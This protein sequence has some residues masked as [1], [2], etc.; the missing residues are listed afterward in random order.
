[1]NAERHEQDK[2]EPGGP[3]PPACGRTGTGVDS[4][5][6]HL[7]RQQ[8]INDKPAPPQETPVRPPPERSPKE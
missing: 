7:D 4:I 3:P 5:L 1:M 6:P 2:G 8:R